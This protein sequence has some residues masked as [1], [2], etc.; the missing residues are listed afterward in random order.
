[1]DLL[2]TDPISGR[3]TGVAKTIRQAIKAME[4]AVVPYCPAGSCGLFHFT[5]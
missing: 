2:V 3:A 4:G 5:F 1:M